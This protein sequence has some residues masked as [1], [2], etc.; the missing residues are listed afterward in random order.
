MMAEHTPQ[1]VLK[2]IG[3]AILAM[4]CFATLDTT[5]KWVSLSAPLM[6]AMFFRYT[7]QAVAT[8][9]IE[10]PR[11]GRALLQTEHLGLHIARGGLLLAT[12]IFAFLSLKHMPVGEFTAIV[13][14]TPLVVTLLA[15]RMLHEKVS[16]LRLLLVAGGFIGTLVIVRPEGADFN[17]ALLFPIGV[18]LAN[19]GF[20]L[21]TS[22]MAKTEDPM[23]MQFYTGWT[24]A[25]VALCALPFIWVP[26]ASPAVWAGLVF[27]GF[28]GSLGHFIFIQAFKRAPA[29]ILMPYMYAQIAFAMLGGLVDV[30]PRP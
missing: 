13:L 15:A 2:G 14:L 3:L 8:T 23:T 5:T 22:S 21:L 27:M 25:V 6:V 29:S 7:F 28:M 16:R 4:A 20:Q 26:I 12:S 1:Q 30:L 10:L 18:V 11:Q 9:A 24:G 19:A 17:W